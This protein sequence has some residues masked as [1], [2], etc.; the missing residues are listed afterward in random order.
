MSRKLMPPATT[1]EELRD[2]QQNFFSFM[3][4][5]HPFERVLSAYRDKFYVLKDSPNEVNKA[6]KFYR[7]YGKR[8]I[9]KFR[10]ENDTIA[11]ESK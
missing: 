2:I 11:Q 5:R 7:L 6:A 10:L 8:I 1:I 4:V 3:T 9:Q